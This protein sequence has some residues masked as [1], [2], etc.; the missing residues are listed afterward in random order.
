MLE[1]FVSVVVIAIWHVLMM[2]RNMMHKSHVTKP[3]MDL[4]LRQKSRSKTDFVL[5]AHTVISF[6]PID[7]LRAKYG[8]E[9]LHR[10]TTTIVTQPNLVSRPNKH[11]RLSS[12]T[13][14]F[15]GNKRCKMNTGLYELPLKYFYS[16]ALQSAVGVTFSHCTIK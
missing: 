9:S 7:E 3:A 1:K 2:H 15:L 10:T 13:S 4:I 14:G 8:T 5:P 12:D 11:A 6:A 16:F